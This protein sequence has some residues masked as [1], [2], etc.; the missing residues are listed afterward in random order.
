V[1]DGIAEDAA[2]GRLDV[3]VQWI[4]ITR[5]CGELMDLRPGEA[6]C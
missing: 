2:A 4:A 3:D 1:D 5:P 6:E